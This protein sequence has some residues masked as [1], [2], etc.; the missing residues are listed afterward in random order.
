MKKNFFIFLTALVVTILLGH[1]LWAKVYIDIRSPSFRK[2]PIA[3]P[4]FKASTSAGQ[5][6]NLGERATEILKEDLNISG[7]FALI[8][9]PASP[10]SQ[11]PAPSG[12]GN[13]RMG[14]GPESLDFQPWA[15]LGAEALAT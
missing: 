8:T 6:M 10:P 2:F 4:P 12:P 14:T 15:N 1:L 5:E 7:F 13:D 11:T 9:P 3:L